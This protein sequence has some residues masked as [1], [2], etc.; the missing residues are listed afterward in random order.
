M[1]CFLHSCTLTKKIQ[2]YIFCSK[3]Q[4]YKIGFCMISEDPESELSNKGKAAQ[5]LTKTWMHKMQKQNSKQK[6]P[7]GETASV[8]ECRKRETL[9]YV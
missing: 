7:G 8:V 3:A 6:E 1:A 9:N 2:S 4:Q 5:F